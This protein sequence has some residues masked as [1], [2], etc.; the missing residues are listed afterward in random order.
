MCALE[1]RG[2]PTGLALSISSHHHTHTHTHTH[3][4][5]CV[6]VLTLSHV[7]LFATLWVV[8]CQALRSMGFSRQEY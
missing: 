2:I 3:A 6:C 4:H 1:R 5:T 8:A 7:Q